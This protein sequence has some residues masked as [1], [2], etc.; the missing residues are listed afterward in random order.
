MAIT[1]GQLRAQLQAGPIGFIPKPIISF[2]LSSIQTA[3]LDQ[4]DALLVLGSRA[5]H[6]APALKSDI[7][8]QYVAVGLLYANTVSI[9]TDEPDNVFSASVRTLANSA[10]G[11]AG[12]WAYAVVCSA[13]AGAGAPVLDY[14]DLG[15]I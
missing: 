1:H 4:G 13:A 7:T 8:T 14:A 2:T 3:D 9:Q 6:T 5:A 10:A 11:H 12:E 15:Q